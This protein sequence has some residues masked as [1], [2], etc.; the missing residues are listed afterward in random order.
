MIQPNELKLELP[1]D[2]AN[3]AVS[4]TTHV[5]NILAACYDGNVEKVKEMVKVCPELIYAQYNYTPPI[6]L[7][8]REGHVS[9]VDYLLEHG[10][11]DPEYRSYPFL[12]NLQTIAKDRGHSEIAAM[13]KGYSTNPARQKFKGDNGRIHFKRTELQVEFEKA[14]DKNDLSKPKRF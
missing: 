6:H 11:H 1:M 8:V 3:G 9:L 4:T 10:A 5:W 12:D 14:V 2:V 7:A 13:L